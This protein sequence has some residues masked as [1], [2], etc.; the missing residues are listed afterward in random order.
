[1]GLLST[2]TILTPFQFSSRK[3]QADTMLGNNLPDGI[4]KDTML[5]M[6]AWYE[7]WVNPEKI[8]IS[9]SYINTGAQHTA[10]S[11]VTQ[12]F[13]QD[14][15]R[16]QVSGSVG[17]V[18]VQSR[19]E[20]AKSAALQQLIDPTKWSKPSTSSIKKMGANFKKA[21]NQL[22]DGLGDDMLSFKTGARNRLNNSPRL[23]LKRLK[24]LADEKPYY[25]D[26]NGIE[27]YNVKYIKIFTKQFPD[28]VICEG[29]FNSF[30]VPESSDN[31]M[32]IDYN[33][34]F[35]V[36]NKVPITFIQRMAG[37]FAGTGSVAGELL[38][39]S[40]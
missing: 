37:M 39:S 16:M 18:A 35:I 22:T 2:R 12:H 33:F 28:G 19:L 38:R 40:I 21:G 32:T 24:T 34:E 5:S 27:H 29:Y 36:E 3:L 6:L 26:S 11:I 25:I 4:A 9:D 14:V 15:S 20:E 13:R 23:F 7:M 30:T 1:M 10:G 8:D 31:A 17:Y